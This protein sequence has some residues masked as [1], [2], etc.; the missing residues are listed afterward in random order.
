MTERALS[1]IIYL[2]RRLNEFDW[3]PPKFVIRMSIQK[4][5]EDIIN[6]IAAGEVVQRPSNGIKW[7]TLA[8]K[9]LIENSIDAEA[10][11]LSISI[12]EGGLRELTVIDNGK[13]VLLEDF[14]LL[15][16]RFATSKIRSI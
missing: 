5:S 4:L 2:I 11:A 16:E 1:V 9:E 12:V 6:K 10:T 13:G 14:P 15:C 8:I 7:L 3:R